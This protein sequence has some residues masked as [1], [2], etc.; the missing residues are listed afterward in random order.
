MRTYPP[1]PRGCLSRS[2]LWDNHPDTEAKNFPDRRKSLMFPDVSDIQGR[3]EYW[4]YRRDHR[5]HSRL[6]LISSVDIWRMAH[7]RYVVKFS[8]RKKKGLYAEFSAKIAPSVL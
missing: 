7:N 4:G 1:F 3:D 5:Y 2:F 6:T 8:F